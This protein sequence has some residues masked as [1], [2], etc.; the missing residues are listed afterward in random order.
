MSSGWLSKMLYDYYEY[1]GD[2]EYLKEVYQV[3]LDSAKFYKDLLIDDGKGNLVICPSTSPENNYLTKDG[4]TPLDKTTT[5]TMS[6]VRDIFECVVKSAKILKFDVEDYERLLPCL[7]GYRICS[8]GRLNEWYDEHEEWDVHHRHVSHLYGLFPSNQ[9]NIGTPELMEASKKTL[10]KRGD[11]GTGWSLA[12]K[13][14]FWAKLRDGNHAQ[15]LL[16]RQL[17]PVDSQN[18]E[19]NSGGGSYINLF[20]SHPL[21]QIDGNFGACS[22]IAQMLLQCDGEKVTLLP[23]L[24]DDWKDGEVRGLAL[25]GGAWIDFK[26]YDKK[27]ASYE[28]HNATKSYDVEYGE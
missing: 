6:I 11:A 18:A 19:R 26:W 14:N 16:D 28:I 3:L 1:T 15:I 12:W 24:P 20:C 25:H 5:I 8:D 7:L 21:F 23:A 27:I 10:L 2:I 17:K 22:G 9:I 4:F 13:V